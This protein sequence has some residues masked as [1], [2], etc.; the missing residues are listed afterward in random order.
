MG[1]L[2]TPSPRFRRRILTG[3]G[4]GALVASLVFGWGVGSF[5]ADQAKV[6][7]QARLL[8]QVEEIAQNINPLPVRRLTF[9]PFDVNLEAFSRLQAEIDAYSKALPGFKIFTLGM[10]DGR[11]APGPR[12]DAFRNT[13]VDPAYQALFT[14]KHA[15]VFDLSA[16]APVLDPRTGN[17]SMVVGLQGPAN[18]LASR[19]ALI[20][21]QGLALALILFLVVMTIVLTIRW[22]SRQ[23][24][25][26]DAWIH[27]WTAWIL[28]ALGLGAT[29]LAASQIQGSAE[30][31]ARQKMALTC[32]DIEV[33]IRDR[34]AA[35]EQILRSGAAFFEAADRVTREGWRR[36]M[37]RQNIDVT[38]PGIQGTGFDIAVPREQLAAHVA[39][40][41][42]T[43]LTDYHVWPAGDRPLY[44][45]ILYLEPFA[46]RNLA[47]IGFDMFTEPVRRQ[48]METARD[49][50][51]PALSGKVVLA[52]ETGKEVQAGTVMYVPVYRTG[53][54]TES[55][56]QRRQALVGWVSSPYRMTD[57][58]RGILGTGG[59]GST[60]GLQLTI[61]DGVAA[62][63]DGLLYDSSAGAD[64][65]Y[66]PAD[67]LTL[68]MPL[69][70]AGRLWTLHF[71][72]LEPGDLLDYHAA[73]AMV[74]AGVGFSILLFGL[75]SS[76]L[77]T[78]SRAH[79]LAS[80][81]TV[82]VRD[83]EERIRL[84]LDSTAEAIYGIDMDGNCTFCNASC[85]SILG[86]SGPE[87]LLGKNMHWQIHGKHGDGSLFPVEDCRI[88]QAF[89]NNRNSHVDD[90]VLWRADG[91]SFPAE[92]WSYPERLDGRVVGAVV[93]FLD[94]SE[95]RAADRE[96]ERLSRMLQRTQKL[97][98]VGVLAGGLGHDFNNLLAGMSGHVELAKL[99]LKNQRYAE[100]AERLAKV[101]SVFDRAKALARQLLTFSKGG[102]PVLARQSLGPLVRE[103]VG[104]ALSGSEIR[105][106][107]EVAEGL[108]QCECDAPQI[109]Q[110]VDNFLINAKQV[111]PPGGTIVVR[112]QNIPS[113][114][115]KIR[116][117]VTD[118]GPGI[119][120][121]VLEKIFDPFFTTKSTGTGLGLAI[122][123]SIVQRH[124]GSIQVETALGR[125]STFTMELPACLDEAA[126]AA[127]THDADFEG[128]GWA[129]VMDDE[130]PL[131]DTVGGML[132]TFGFQV[133]R[134][135]TGEEALEEFERFRLDGGA[136]KLCLLDLTIPGAMGGWETAQRLK[137]AGHRALV[138]AMSGYSEEDPSAHPGVADGWIT[139]PFHRAELAGLLTRLFAGRTSGHRVT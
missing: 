90:E 36:F 13:P 107:V 33:R 114:E 108:W 78:R 134:A 116:I 84:L 94:I 73:W 88:F 112:A 138:V 46:G 38:L 130:E 106:R 129:L 15:Q 35:H 12:T 7:E 53:A 110:V 65:A 127:A 51:T 54:P 44:T 135:K 120:P 92:Y 133:I 59:T 113:A 91:T 31:A 9:T 8:D 72:A 34:M 99:N 4:A 56:E 81:L 27:R 89:Q 20:R 45:S 68:Q 118:E 98:S 52:Q 18:E 62:T 128:S 40:V 2:Q 83:R 87:D 104:F 111:T 26:H 74:A 122:A 100:A 71:T 49:E 139:K 95:R 57:L 132:E 39:T 47:A 63:R 97:E 28:L 96:T 67:V 136:L 50:D 37:E 17:V 76:L 29:A 101:D 119:P 19:L 22:Y 1:T 41:R 66:R 55:T 61:Y 121:D 30:E 131:R 48:A 3:F 137:A 21:V 6:N 43:G 69:V 58:L 24:G 25:K 124:R 126:L 11:L 86:Y 64:A 70:V 5:Q 105:P 10:R 123:H 16:L 32:R 115:P 109:G 117:A 125:G 80:D 102:V 93:S 23:G 77:N 60:G 82:E 14:S 42:A 103:W 75:W 79:R 85:V